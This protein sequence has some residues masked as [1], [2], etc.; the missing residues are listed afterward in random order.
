VANPPQPAASQLQSDSVSFRKFAGLKNIVESER[1][2]PDELEIAINVDLDDVGELHRRQGAQLKVPGNWSN[3]F[4]SNNNRIYGVYNGNL[5]RV[6]PNF[7]TLIMQTGFDPTV[8]IAY[9]QVGDNLYWS[10]STQNG[11]IDTIHD[12]SGPWLGPSLGPNYIPDLLDPNA[13]QAPA[14]PAGTWWLSPIV[15]PKSTLAPIKGRILGPP[16]FA[17][18]LAYFNGRIYMGIGKTVWYTE[19]YLYNYVNVTKNFFNFE[20]DV[21]MVGSVTDGIYVGTKNDGVWFLSPAPRIEGHPAGAMKR[22]RVMDSGV[23]PGSMVYMPGELGN[24]PQVG[25]DSDTPVKVSILFMTGNGYCVA[26]DGG[27]TT[28]FSEDKFIFP[29]SKVASAMYRQQQGVHQYVAVLNSQG[30]PV[31]NARISDHVDTTLRKAGSWAEGSD[32]ITISE[33]VSYTYL[34]HH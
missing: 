13:P 24:P 31:S 34:P 3:I 25:L 12:T 26:Q 33:N 7:A 10:C 27:N 17:S 16:P 4:T 8:P 20:S 2:G 28:N 5:V 15:N 11:I 23:V 19:L 1:L 32:Q 30:D 14:L 18:F 29:T 9:E 6:Y 21:T 22:L